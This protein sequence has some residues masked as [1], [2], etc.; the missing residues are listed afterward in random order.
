MMLRI[1]PHPAAHR[2]PSD[3]ENPSRLGLQKTLASSFP[4]PRTLTHYILNIIY[5]ML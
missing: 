3:P 5:S 1:Q 2:T 4:M